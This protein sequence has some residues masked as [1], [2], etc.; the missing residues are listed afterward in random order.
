MNETWPRWQARIGGLKAVALL[1]G[2]VILAALLSCI[3]QLQNTLKN[4]REPQ[5]V[6]I[7]QLVREEIGEGQYVTVAG[8]AFYQEGY[9][10]TKNGK[11]VSRYY[12]LLNLAK[13]EVIFVRT[14]QALPTVEQAGA[15]VVGMTRAV[16]PDLRSIM[17]SS[18][19]ELREAGL[20]TT[21][22]LYL[23]EGQKPTRPG[24]F[25]A[26]IAGLGLLLALCVAT[27]FFPSTVFRPQPVDAAAVPSTGAM[28]KA[29]GRFKKVK[30][31]EPS[32]EFG[33]GGHSFRETIANLV[34]LDAQRLMVYVRLVQRHT[35]YGVIPLFKQQSDWAVVV[36]PSHTRDI[37]PGKLYGWRDRWAVRMRCEDQKGRL[38]ALILSFDGAGAQAS[39][40]NMLHERG[41]PV[42]IGPPAATRADSSVTREPAVRVSNASF[43]GRSIVA[44][45]LTIG[46]Y[47]L[48][49]AVVALLLFIIYAQIVV[50]NR[51]NI[52]LTLA[53]LI[54]AG[55]I[56]WS[57]LPRID[58]FIPP[59]PRL[60]PEKNPDL[61]RQVNDIARQVEQRPPDDVYLLPEVN[62]FVSQRGGLMGIG[63]RRVMGIGLP[64]LQILTVPQFR[65]VVAHEF[66]HFDGGDT[67][68]APWIYRTRQSIIRTVSGLGNSW[69]QFLFV[70]YAKL[71]LRITQSISRNQEFVA[72]RLAAQTAG[73]RPL[74]EGLRTIHGAAPAF[75]AFMQNEVAPTVYAG[76]RPSLV[77]GFSMFLSEP[78]VAEAIGRSVAHEM[79]TSETNPYDTH[80]S[81]KKRI[82]AAETLP[83]G[84]DD[85]DQTP[86]LAL[87]QNV[88]D[89]ERALFAQLVEPERAASL[90]PIDWQNAATDVW[91][92]FWGKTVREYTSGLR[93]V[94]AASLPGF[95]QSPGELKTLVQQSAGRPLDKDDEGR[96]VAQIT[97]MALAVAL[98]RQGWTV[99]TSPGAQVSFQREENQIEPF[100]AAAKLASGE[101]PASAWQAFCEQVG[102]ADLLLV[103]EG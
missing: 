91:L 23:A 54:T 1:I 81:L 88:A 95:L 27:L 103:A 6:Q 38:Q 94:T 37:E 39:F 65:T 101:M 59:G 80:P 17:E 28:V 102:I 51:I 72:D 93:G 43:L 22:N 63:S 79:E 33:R 13:G 31:V 60:E 40:L 67:R 87:V 20:T 8:T 7:G 68:L 82:A 83:P 15:S 50:A 32:I 10:E 44:V 85:T 42:E 19:P 16:E 35:L 11:L 4:P 96:T 100:V 30:R 47:G 25:I 41:F 29:T 46:F 69:L 99:D 5:R 71:F 70:S 98:A 36:D 64:L 92:P 14:T 73:S 86:A 49:L 2:L 52:R 18:L 78:A 21:T 66:G 84:A 53:C 89:L 26:A 61:F 9:D 62:A 45:L 56:L 74:V 90:K 24:F 3:Y 97:A 57:I 75:E 58:R 12:G 34:P 77:E 55:V 76:Y 48:A